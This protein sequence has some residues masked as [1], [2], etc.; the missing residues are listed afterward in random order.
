MH[1][2]TL[3]VSGGLGLLVTGL[4]YFLG[5]A[6]LSLR[7]SWQVFQPYA[8]LIWVLCLL[9]TMDSLYLTHSTALSARSSFRYLYYYLPIVGLELVLLMVTRGESPG[10]QIRLGF[11]LGVFMAVRFLLMLCV[12]GHTL[13]IHRAQNRE[14]EP[15]RLDAESP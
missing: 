8:P 5:D 1:L 2:Q 15:D 14:V 6:I 12:A 11:Y 7:T 13:L 9:S 3:L 10:E 4:F